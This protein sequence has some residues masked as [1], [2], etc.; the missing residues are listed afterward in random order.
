MPSWVYKKGHFVTKILHDAFILAPLTLEN[1]DYD[2]TNKQCV[3]L[4][5]FQP[6]RL[7][8]F[9]SQSALS[10]AGWRFADADAGF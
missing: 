5:I 4:L 8:E 10:L 3:G 2:Q 7:H 1:H 9:N 6:E